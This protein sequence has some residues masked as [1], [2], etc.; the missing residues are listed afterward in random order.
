MQVVCHKILCMLSY[1]IWAT[2]TCKTSHA[3]IPRSRAFGLGSVGRVTPTHLQQLVN[4][5]E[6]PFT[7]G[8]LLWKRVLMRVDDTA[9]KWS[10]TR[11]YTLVSMIERARILLH[12]GTYKIN[13]T[14]LYVQRTM[15]R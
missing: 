11:A 8:S 2:L 7:L 9:K 3:I 13:V 14:L 10:K 15:L 1:D 12:N 4:I 6:K 5:S